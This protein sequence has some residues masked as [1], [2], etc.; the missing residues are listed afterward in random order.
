MEIIM[1]LDKENKFNFFTKS[2]QKKLRAVPI[3]GALASISLF[4][5]VITGDALFNS[6]PAYR[7]NS[8]IVSFQ[9][10]VSTVQKTSVSTTALTFVVTPYNVSTQSSLGDLSE[11]E[12]LA[13]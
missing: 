3:L 8:N 9:E 10:G 12:K 13:Y 2:Q 4:L 11:K 1:Q 5:Y 6:Y 7:E